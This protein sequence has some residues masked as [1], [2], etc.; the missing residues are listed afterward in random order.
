MRQLARA[1]AY[2]E[3]DA[4]PITVQRLTGVRG[5]DLHRWFYRNA[6]DAQRGRAPFGTQWYPYANLLQQF[7]AALFSALF[8][9]LCQRGFAADD[10][11]LSAYLGYRELGLP[12]PR[13]DFDRAFD[14]AAHITGHW[15]SDRA[16]YAVVPC[17][18]CSNDALTEYGRQVPLGCPFCRMLARY[19]LDPRVQSHLPPP[20][21]R[22]GP[23]PTLG[24]VYLS[25]GLRAHDQRPS[26]PSPSRRT[27]R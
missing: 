1:R 5:P 27:R 23:A 2:V 22:P 21:A 24:I 7:D 20:P 15:L 10:A 4:R 17:R 13:I 18:T 3:L 9:R 25:P 11:L 26:P 19:A 14:L 16:H 6:D 8:H 12:Q